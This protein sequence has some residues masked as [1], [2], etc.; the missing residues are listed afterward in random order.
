MWVICSDSKSNC[1]FSALASAFFNKSS[2]NWEA[3]EFR[4]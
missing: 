4:P 1:F 2:K 3:C